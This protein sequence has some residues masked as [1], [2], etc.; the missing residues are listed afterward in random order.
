MLPLFVLCSTLI[1]VVIQATLLPGSHDSPVANST[2]SHATASNPLSH[3]GWYFSVVSCAALALDLAVSMVHKRVNLRRVRQSRDIPDL[4]ALKDLK[5]YVYHGYYSSQTPRMQHAHEINGFATFHLVLRIIYFI[6]ACAELGFLAAHLRHLYHTTHDNDPDN[7]ACV[8]TELDVVL[9]HLVT[10]L[11][12][13]V[14]LAYH[15]QHMRHYFKTD[16]RERT[17]AYDAAIR[18]IRSSTVSPAMKDYTIELLQRVLAWRQVVPQG[19]DD[20]LVAIEGDLD[21]P[22]LTN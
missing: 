7:D 4:I 20:E 18:C 22:L 12:D 13:M 17:Q 16:T 5:S 14:L 2:D 8:P 21:E 6:C 11:L 10:L 3:P 1:T 9:T 19:A 15:F